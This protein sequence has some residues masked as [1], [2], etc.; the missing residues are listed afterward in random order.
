M[1]GSDFRIDK[2]AFSVAPLSQADD[3]I[4]FWLAKT[5]HERLEALEQLRQ[6]IYGYTS[7]MARVERVFEV[8]KMEK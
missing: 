4:E 7:E 5:P 8:V 1:S 2:S 3:D 6:T